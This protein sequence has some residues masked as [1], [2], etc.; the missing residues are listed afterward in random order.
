[1]HAGADTDPNVR[2]TEGPD[3]CLEMPKKAK[4]KKYDYELGERRSPIGPRMVDKINRIKKDTI[5]I[6]KT[7]RDARL[8]MEATAMRDYTAY[9]I[10]IIEKQ[11]DMN[12]P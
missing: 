9:L 4:K 1:M 6:C 7:L 11:R 10:D 5:D 8:Y 2:Y 12:N 3:P